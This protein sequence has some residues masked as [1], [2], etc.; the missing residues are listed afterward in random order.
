[1]MKLLK[2]SLMPLA[3]LLIVMAIFFSLFRALTPL[4][5]QYKGQI[6][7]HLSQLLG[8]PV[9]I[10]DMETSWYWFEPVLKL[11]E[12]VISSQKNQTLKL[13]K[14]LV[15]INLFSSLWHWQIKPGVLYIQD[16]HLTLRQIDK[17][18]QVDGFSQTKQAVTLDENTYLPILTWLLSQEKIIIKQVSL[19]IYCND[20]TLIA[21]E[22]VNITAFN[23]YGHYRVKGYGKLAQKIPTQVTII[24]DIEANLDAL[25]KTSAQVYLSF[26]QVFPAQWQKFV[27]NRPIE[28]K[29]GESDIALWFDVT[30]ARLSALQST[31]ELKHIQWKQK[32]KRKWHHVQSATA[33]LAWKQTNSGWQLS[34]DRLNLYQDNVLWPENRFSLNYQ[35]NDDRYQ[36]FV[37]HVPL[38][39]I[40]ATDISWPKQW[41]FILDLSPEGELHDTQVIV[42]ANQLDY[43]LTRFSNLGWRSP[44]NLPSVRQISGVLHWQP[45][46]G[47]LELD[48]EHTIVMPHNLP[49]IEFGQ[50]NAAFDWK[51]LNNGLRVSMERFVLSRPDVVLTAE[52]VLDDPLQASANLRMKAQFSAT[53]AKHWLQYIP[54]NGLKPKL[55]QWLKQNIKRIDKVSGE[56]I[57]DGALADFPFDKKPGQFSI[58]SYLSG[59]DLLITP[60]WPLTRE[61]EAHLQMNQR[62]LDVDINH[63]LLQDISIDKLSLRIP[64]IGLGKEALL[65]HSNIHAQAKQIRNYVYASPLGDRFLKWKT[66]EIRDPVELDLQLDIP[67]YPA[68]DHVFV[69]GELILDNNPLIFHYG[70]KQQID[71]DKTSGILQFDELGIT[72]SELQAAVGGSPIVMHIQ[73]VMSPNRQTEF[74]LEGST[75]IQLLRQ[76]F[77]LPILS[78]M[79]GSTNVQGVFKLDSDPRKSD[80]LQITSSLAGVAIDLPPPLGKKSDE[81]APF[82]IDV[83]FNAGVSKQLRVLY[84]AIQVNGKHVLPDDWAL[85]L[86][87]PNVHANVHYQPSTHTISGT[88]ESLNIADLSALKRNMRPSKANFSPGD[89]PNLNLVID[90]FKFNNLNIGQVNLKSTSFSNKWKLESCQIKTPEYLLTVQGVWEKIGKKDTTTLEANL[91]LSDLGAALARF[92]IVPAVEAQRSDLI[93]K[94]SWPGA[95]HDFSLEKMVGDLKIVVRDGRITHLDKAT[96]EKLGLGKLLS[97]LSLQTIPR[98]LKLDFTDLSQDGY[99]FDEFKGS[100]KLKDGVMN[101]Q[102]SFIDGPVAFASMKGDLDLVNHL[103]D[104]DLRIS[105]YITASLPIVATIAGGP[106]AGIATWAASK[107]INK[108]MQQISAYT[109][110]V[111]GPWDAPIV[112]QV[113]IYRKKVNG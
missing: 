59:I 19:D 104:V 92:G 109:Y 73:S 38:K 96:E 63:A 66:L 5:K 85:N 83:D 33:N 1:M 15:G 11:D 53:K 34:G 107:L 39:A 29:E 28:I 57:V 55:E 111:S 112:Q 87:E 101:T 113:R 30:N 20:K 7:Q 62:T 82:A 110:K 89:I 76:K 79:E 86:Q 88:I 24:A 56:I 17:Q 95:L 23:S 71:I 21:L 99:S 77:S 78:V 18:W 9:S 4:A 68:R 70:L 43:I 67:L 54:S 61:I 26:A 97:I 3:I 106:I 91:H 100:F 40:M 32:E 36:L 51:Q 8:Q 69:Q 52:G 75:S 10:Q 41:R 90:D 58:N 72:A 65:I 46:E 42:K 81:I 35:L 60:R 105:P 45:T 94:G 13:N 6:E 98:R 12:V 27:P 2:K 64:D 37:K 103:Y 22:D 44:H 16:A 108:G 25:N 48:G 31:I 14:L 80:H 102:D 50:L 84:K 49:P 74:N 93:F 47:R